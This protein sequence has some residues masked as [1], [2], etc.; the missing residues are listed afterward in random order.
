M[1][2]IRRE[3]KNKKGENTKLGESVQVGG[4]QQETTTAR[5]EGA[6]ISVRCEGQKAF[7][8]YYG[9]TM[10]SHTYVY[11]LEWRVRVGLFAIHTATHFYSMFSISQGSG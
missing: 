10:P 2:K 9:K 11:T 5:W 4:V 1:A 7:E 6:S 8:A 3:A